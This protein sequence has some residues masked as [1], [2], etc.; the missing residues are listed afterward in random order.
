M[1]TLL[2]II[3]GFLAI[4]FLYSGAM[5]S[6]RKREEL[7]SLGQTGV[8]NLTYPA[9]RFIGI[10]E[11]LGAI[12]IIAPAATGILP[13]LTPVTALC[14]ALIMVFAMPIHYKRAEYK[15]VAFNALLLI[16]S[17]FTAYMR[18]R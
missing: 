13:A 9:I 18:F 5:K 17:V 4:V 6:S 3:Q 16:L 7:V 8:A 10:T 15:S 12:G 2:W 11:I 14:F 1:N